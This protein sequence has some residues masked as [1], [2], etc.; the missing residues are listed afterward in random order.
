MKNKNLSHD[1][2]YENL[3]SDRKAQFFDIFKN[4]WKTLFL[5]GLWLLVG[6]LPYIV[7][8]VFR[9]FGYSFMVS[10]CQEAGLSEADT[11]MRLVFFNLIVDAINV[12]S[13]VALSFVLAGSSRVFRNLIFNDGVLFK[14]DFIR[15]IKD[16]WLSYFIIC[17]IF[18][19]IKSGV[20]FAI[21]ISNQTGNMTTLILS[22]V[23]LISFYVVIAPM[24]AFMVEMNQ[25]YQITLLNNLKASIKMSLINVLIVFLFALPLYFAQYISFIAILFVDILIICIMF[26]ILGP[27]YLLL[28]KLFVISRFDKY[29]NQS[30]Y[31]DFYRKGLSK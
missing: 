2:G 30:D 21:N 26:L 28:W 11:N 20:N 19:V 15:G 18:G 29:I 7:V 6:A 14:D 24:M 8:F 5:I 12:L 9:F 3:P 22:G 17:I 10:A 25:I 16:T 31:P 13:Y 1:F 4:E 23:L 27:I